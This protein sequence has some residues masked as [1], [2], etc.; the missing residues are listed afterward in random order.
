MPDDDFGWARQDIFQRGRVG[1]PRD[2]LKVL[3]GNS[4]DV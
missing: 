2:L 1:A 4:L 3:F